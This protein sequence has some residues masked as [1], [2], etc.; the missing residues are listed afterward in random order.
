MSTTYKN[1]EILELDENSKLFKIY[2]ELENL[3]VDLSGIVCASWLTGIEFEIYS[4]YIKD[5]NYNWLLI[6]ECKNYCTENTNYINQLIKTAIDHDIFIA[7]IR[8][9]KYFDNSCPITFKN[10]LKLYHN[11]KNKQITTF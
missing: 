5:I 7:W 1:I 9:D 4:W 3:C 11:Y 6:D 8:N 2:D 10:F